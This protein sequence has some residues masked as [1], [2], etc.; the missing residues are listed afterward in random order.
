MPQSWRGVTH[1]REA[2]MHPLALAIPRF[3]QLMVPKKSTKIIYSTR[4]IHLSKAPLFYCWSC[5]FLLFADEN[6]A[7]SDS[8]KSLKTDFDRDF[9]A[10]AD[11][12]LAPERRASITAGNLTPLCTKPL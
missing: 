10:Y 9:D 6:N 4:K 3:I 8:L 5:C 11:N 2:Q 1:I 7:D 12:L